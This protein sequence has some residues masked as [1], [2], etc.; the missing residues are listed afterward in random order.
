MTVKAIGGKRRMTDF[1]RLK[2][3]V[4]DLYGVEGD[5]QASVRVHEIINGKSGWAGIVEVFRIVHPQAKYAYA[6]NYKDDG[7][8]KS[9]YPVV[10]GIPPID[11]AEDA[12]RAY[13]AAK[14]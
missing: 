6:W 7:G 9:H 11:S 4:R 5:Y 1:D 13:F 10:L 3:A 2:Q 12:V 8:G 14:R